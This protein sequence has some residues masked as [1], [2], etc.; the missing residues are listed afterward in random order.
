MICNNCG[1]QNAP[2]DQFCGSCGK[3]LE[4]TADAGAAEEAV[5]DET[6]IAPPPESTADAGPPPPPPPAPSAAEAAQPTA[7]EPGPPV[8]VQHVSS[9]L[10]AGIICWNCGRQNPSSRSFCQQCGERLNVGAARAG[11]AGAGAAGAGAA[12]AGS[13]RADDSSG[14]RRM[15]AI[16]IGVIALLLLAGGAAAIFLGGGPGASPSPTP[17]DAALPLSPS[18]DASVEPSPSVDASPSQSPLPTPS[19]P[20]GTSPSPSPSGTPTAPPTAPPTPAPP[21][22]AP[23]P[24]NCDNSTSPNR[25]LTLDA[26]KTSHRIADHVAWCVHELIFIAQSGSGQLKLFLTNPAYIPDYGMETI[27]WH[28]AYMPSDFQDSVEYMPDLDVIQ[29][30][31]LL[32]PGTVI[33][34]QIT[35]DA[36]TPDCSGMMQ[37]GADRFPAP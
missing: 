36:A 30:Y 33:T 17:T 18:P 23:T 25:Y 31:R 22:P 10:A 5:S 27:G 6:Q 37:M 21:T 29:P 32:L 24:L 26:E 1:F 2:G 28:E 8:P 13:R 16:G 35:C 7:I 15:L 9:S 3:F 34:F 4:W 12:R 14:N 11:A 20:A 19:T